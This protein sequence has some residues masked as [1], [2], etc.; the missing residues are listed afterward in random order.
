[1]SIKITYYDLTSLDYSSFFLTGLLQNRKDFGYKLII[2]KKVPS[3]LHD[4]AIDVEWVKILFS[5]CLFK[6]ELSNK[7]FYFCIDTRDSY[8]AAKDEGLGYHMPVLSKVRYYFKVNYRDEVIESDPNLKVY[9]SKIIP[10]GPFFAIRPPVLLRFL[11]KIRHLRRFPSLEEIRN[12]RNVK[13]DLDIFFVVNFWGDRHAAD[14]EFRYQIMKEV[15]R[16]PSV[17]SV[18]GFVTDGKLPERFAEF[19]CKQYSLK[20]FLRNV[21]RAKVAIYVRGLHECLSFKLGQLLAL[22]MPI[23]GQTIANNKRLLYS[24]EHFASQFAFDDPKE[25]VQEAVKLLSE[26]ERMQMLGHAN[27]RTFDA[28]FTPQAVTAGTLKLI[29]NDL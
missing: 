3:I 10:I 12:L 20:D 21:A 28:K 14:N 9:A 17:V 1:M 8:K 11:P 15:K 29:I 23:V 25:I 26:P 6:V 5:I 22:G 19:R 24:N 27:A 2:S 16:F 4:P 18:T 13:K 7:E